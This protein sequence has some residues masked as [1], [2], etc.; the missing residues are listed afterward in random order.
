MPSYRWNRPWSM[1]T[2]RPPSRPSSSRP[3]WPGAVAAGQPGRS[4][5]GM[6]TAS[7]RSSARPPSPDPRTI[8]TSGTS[9]G[10]LTDRCG[11]RGDAG[12]LLGGRDRA[13]RI[14]GHGR[15][16]HAGLQGPSSI[17]RPRL[18]GFVRPTEVSTPGCR[19]RPVGR[20]VP[21]SGRGETARGL[22]QRSAR[23]DRR[24]TKVLDVI[25]VPSILSAPSGKT[26][27]MGRARRWS[28][29][30]ST[31]LRPRPRSL[32]TNPVHLWITLW[33]TV[34]SATHREHLDLRQV[35]GRGASGARS[36]GRRGRATCPRGTPRAARRWSRRA[37]S[38]GRPGPR[39]RTGT[40]TA[41]RRPT[42]ARACNRGR[43]GR[44][45]DEMIPNSP[46][47]SR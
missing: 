27:V 10:A 21:R 25:A 37:G 16:G 45:T 19:S 24:R 6:A 4:A 9:G 30:L 40:C 42:V 14:D 5:K 20:L 3:A 41:C 33:M 29:R 12:R 31:N 17:G 32:S 22:G 18:G 15:V 34:A 39:R 7:S 28:T 43:T 1:T 2:G 44:V 46:R 26:Y 35:G 13:R 38:P 11:E 8:P 36:S 23:S 47:P